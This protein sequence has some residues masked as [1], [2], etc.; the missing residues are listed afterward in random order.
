MNAFLRDSKRCSVFTRKR[1]ETIRRSIINTIR[2][3]SRRRFKIMP[4]LAR[5]NN[6]LFK[7][8]LIQPSDIFRIIFLN[9]LKAGLRLDYCE[10]SLLNIFRLS[11]INNY[12]GKTFKNFINTPIILRKLFKSYTRIYIKRK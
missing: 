11:C 6:I 1:I 3:N 5:N 9:I 4:R 2:T 7:S 8:R 12:V 10:G